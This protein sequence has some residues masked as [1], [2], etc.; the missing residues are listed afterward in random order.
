MGI[1]CR[2]GQE[3][4]ETVCV[5]KNRLF[6]K[7]QAGYRYSRK[8]Q[9]LSAGLY[10]IYPGRHV[11][12]KGKHSQFVPA[13]WERPFLSRFTNSRCGGYILFLDT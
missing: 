9:H 8:K 3:S 10:E 2:K 1:K 12:S 5:K 11:S 7:P 6:L 13:G 4:D